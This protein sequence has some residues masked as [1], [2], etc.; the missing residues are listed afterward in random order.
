MMR[1]IGFKSARLLVMLF[2]FCQPSR[3]VAPVDSLRENALYCTEDDRVIFDD[4]I[5][6]VK[7][8]KSLPFA[9]LVIVTARFFMN[10]PYV[11]STLEF[12]P[13]GL[14]VNLRG[15]DCSTFVET[16]LALARTVKIYDHPAFEDFCGQLRQIRYR[17]GIINDYTDRLHYFTDWI[18][19]NERRGIVR[20]VTEKAGGKPYRPNLNFM[21]SHP[22][23]YRQLQS[24]PGYV[25]VMREKEREISGRNAYS[26][27]PESGIGAC[28]HALEDGDIV[29]FVTG[30]KGLDVAHVGFVCRSGG[31]LTFIHA[32][33]SAKK[34]IVNSQP[35][36]VYAGKI[37][38]CRGIMAVRP[39]DAD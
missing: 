3:S 32:S 37:K 18:Y 2:V 8:S 22:E 19:E 4:Y 29:C 17:A 24:N 26:F 27:I 16:V 7:S 20:D 5:G 33:L 30:I 6:N 23:S 28:G 34:V 39:L 38:H 9:D 14:A 21:S 12:E 10:R 36:S 15:F 25:A 31:L 35:V 13:E 11:A 1:I